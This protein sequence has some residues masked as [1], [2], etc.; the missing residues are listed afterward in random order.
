MFINVQ[1][2][3]NSF[4]FSLF[5]RNLS[6]FGS[7]YKIMGTI[8]IIYVSLCALVPWWL[9]SGYLINVHNFFSLISIFNCQL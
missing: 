9:L 3:I 8:S 7:G 5:Y 1:P 4:D 2:Y 6:N